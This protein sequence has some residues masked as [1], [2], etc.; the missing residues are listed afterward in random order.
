MSD[1]TMQWR[2]EKC[3]EAIGRYDEFTNVEGIKLILSEHFASAP[4]EP[5]RCVWYPCSDKGAPIQE[6]GR[7]EAHPIHHDSNPY[8]GHPFVPS[9]ESADEEKK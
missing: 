6:C 5:P 7:I 9:R 8:R 4:G 1:E 2:I 3:A